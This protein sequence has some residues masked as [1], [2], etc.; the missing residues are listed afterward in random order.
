[1]TKRDKVLL[2][3][4]IIVAVVF[5]SYYFVYEPTIT[6]IEAQRVRAQDLQFE[7]NMARTHEATLRAT[8][9][10]QEEVLENIEEIIAL[11]YPSLP[12]QYFVD[13]LRI[14]ADE[15]EITIDSID[16]QTPSMQGLDRII[17][18]DP[19]VTDPLSI[20]IMDYNALI[21]EVEDPPQRVRPAV[22][23]GGIR[24]NRLV[25]ALTG[26]DLAQYLLY[27]DSIKNT[28]FPIYVSNYSLAVT[29][30]DTLAMSISI[31]ALSVERLTAEQYREDAS[32]FS[33]EIMPPAESLD[34]FALV[35]I[36][37]EDAGP[38]AG[39]EPED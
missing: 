13:L 29:G 27:L 34:N 6:H 12:P 37:E 15:H 25:L 8:L 14:F 4:V 11:Y 2:I 9:A 19:A 23:P 33:F 7:L 22:I 10:T 5:A 21:G 38:E 18:G 32:M 35:Q 16:V 17:P 28:G 39:E 1:M 31:A 24:V 36:P 20:A 3:I 30:E 26:G